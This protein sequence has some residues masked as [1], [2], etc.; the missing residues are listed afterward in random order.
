M[1]SLLTRL[2]LDTVYGS[3]LLS[4]LLCTLDISRCISLSPGH[5]DDINFYLLAS[6][7][8]Q[9][10]CYIIILLC[11]ALGFSC[12]FEVMATT[13]QATKTAAVTKES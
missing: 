5:F 11:N 7:S 6:I 1:A 9:L 3:K 4:L 2:I 12:Q 8:V 13:T 10:L